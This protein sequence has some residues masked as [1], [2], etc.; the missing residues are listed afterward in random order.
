MQGV[1]GAKR[2]LPENNRAE[3]AGEGPYTPTSAGPGLAAHPNGCLGAGS[4]SP[5]APTES[6]AGPARR[7]VGTGECCVYRASKGMLSLQDNG[8]LGSQ[9]KL[10]SLPRWQIVPFH[11]LCN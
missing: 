6:K 11:P 5:P 1:P 3:A 2:I 7:L 4:T 10:N 9:K 8:F